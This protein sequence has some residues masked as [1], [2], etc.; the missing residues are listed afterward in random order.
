MYST[1]LKAWK[2]IVM[3]SYTFTIFYVRVCNIVID[4][5]FTDVWDSL[6]YLAL[7]EMDPH[8]KG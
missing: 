8:K 4:W 1:L 5:Y 6:F 3:Y 2:D 7:E